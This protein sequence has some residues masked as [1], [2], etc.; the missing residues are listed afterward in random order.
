MTVARRLALVLTVIAVAGCSR[1]TTH[2]I[3]TTTVDQRA[4]SAFVD[5][6]RRSLEGTWKVVERFERTAADGRKIAAEQRRVQRPPDHLV[7]AGGTVDAVRAGRRLA[8]A[9][10]AGG[11]MHCADAGPARPFEDDVN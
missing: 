3:P 10:D 1:G 8:C 7:V 11:T 4:A 6:T 9:T 5:A 2:T